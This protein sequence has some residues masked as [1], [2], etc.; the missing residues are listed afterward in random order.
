MS[1]LPMDAMDLQ[2]CNLNLFKNYSP[3]HNC[4]YLRI[5]SLERFS[6]DST[7]EKLDEFTAY[8][9]CRPLGD[10]WRERTETD[11]TAIINAGFTFDLADSTY[12]L[13]DDETGTN[14]THKFLSNFNSD[15][16]FFS[17]TEHNPWKDDWRSTGLTADSLECG[18]AVIDKD[19]IGLIV[20]FDV[21]T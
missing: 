20:F 11:A 4:G 14:Y 13:V 17:N 3:L 1:K 10:R 16:M 18:I 15:K 9:G 5:E 7:I 12:R 2:M 21:S 6:S 8:C 19:T